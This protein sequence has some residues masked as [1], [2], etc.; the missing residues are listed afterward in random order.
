MPF[1]SGVLLL[2][3]GSNGDFIEMHAEKL[4]DEMAPFIVIVFVRLKDLFP[5][6]SGNNSKIFEF[7]LSLEC[8]N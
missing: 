3:G 1:C 8:R 2:A 7:E 5:G 6:K 4:E